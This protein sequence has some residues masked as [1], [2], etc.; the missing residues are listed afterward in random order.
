M[1]EVG[2]GLALHSPSLALLPS[3]RAALTEYHAEGRHLELTP[4]LLPEYIASLMERIHPTSPERVPETVFWGVVRGEYVGRVSL[5]HHLNE[6]LDAWGGH[7]GY[8]ARPSRRRRG[9]GHALLA[10]VLPYAWALGLTRVLLHCDETNLASIRIIEGTGGVFAGS[11]SN[12]EREGAPG[13]AY[14]TERG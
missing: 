2:P 11:R 8:E 12:L 3:F 7:I 1:E 4:E 10:G 14:W 5:R 6:R 9:Y 13:R